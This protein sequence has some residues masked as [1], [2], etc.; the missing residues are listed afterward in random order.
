MVRMFCYLWVCIL[1]GVLNLSVCLG[2]DSLLPGVIIE[3][4]SPSTEPLPVELL[5]LPT[6]PSGSG[7]WDTDEDLLAEELIE[8][9]LERP[10]LEDPA[11]TCS[12]P[13][14]ILWGP[15]LSLEPPASLV[16]SH[17]LLMVFCLQDHNHIEHLTNESCLVHMTLTLSSICFLNTNQAEGKLYERPESDSHWD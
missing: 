1:R 9:V 2:L 11:A 16:C 7:M 5:L 13:F 15:W 17:D 8:T 6:L 3:F 14:L 4:L 10:G 12:W